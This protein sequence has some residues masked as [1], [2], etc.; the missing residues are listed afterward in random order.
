[1]ANRV[2]IDPGIMKIS[3]PGVNVLTAVDDDLLF[4]ADWAGFR[5]L[6]RGSFTL[7]AG[8]QTDS[9][10][11]GKT[12]DTIPLL[13]IRLTSGSYSVSLAALR[14]NYYLADPGSYMAPTAPWSLLEI[15]PTDEDFTITIDGSASTTTVNYVVW[16]FDI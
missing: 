13:Y 3:K 5:V 1:M 9:A 8:P 10:F 16:D 6:T 15:E 2:V 11:Y 12:F 4:N 14:G 7:P